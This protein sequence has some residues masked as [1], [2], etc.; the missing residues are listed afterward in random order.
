MN[1]E[2]LRSKYLKIRK[3]INNKEEND[4]QVFQKV[5]ET[6]EYR[7]CA[8]VLTYV[9]LHDEIDTLKLIKYSLDNGKKVAVPK[10]ENGIINFYYISSLEDLKKGS[11]GILEPIGN[12]IVYS[13]EKSICIIPGVCFD[14]MLNRIGY[15]GGYYDRFLS[16]YNGIK[17]GL[18]YKECI[19]DKI[20]L[21]EHDIKMD[22]IIY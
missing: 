16:S 7:E 17:I 18:T 11:Y 20:D 13:F 1:K 19:V 5:I 12:D 3:E 8:L 6:S 21:D 14:K 15:G 2:E 4:N 9:S 10:C 22:K